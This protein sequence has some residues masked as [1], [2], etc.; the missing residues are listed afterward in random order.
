LET[1]KCGD[2]AMG[3]GDGDED[4]DRDRD[5]GG[6]DGRDIDF[7]GI[8]VQAED[9][10]W[11]WE[12]GGE[13]VVWRGMLS[14]TWDSGAGAGAGLQGRMTRCEVVV[15]EFEGRAE[16]AGQWQWGLP[17]HVVKILQVSTSGHSTTYHSSPVSHAK[18]FP[19]SV[20][21]LADAC[22]IRSPS[23]WNISYP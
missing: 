1:I 16:G 12:Y 21:M 11:R 3:D 10:V 8:R 23:R 20:R 15:S 9:M 14:A 5:G 17:D 7:D 4:E 2:V 19:P 22:A 13:Q 18:P 6:E